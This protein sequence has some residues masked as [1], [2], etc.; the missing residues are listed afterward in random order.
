MSFFKDVKGNDGKLLNRREKVKKGQKI[1]EP[2]FLRNKIE[3]KLFHP[4]T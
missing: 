1:L 2:S 3:N 4:V